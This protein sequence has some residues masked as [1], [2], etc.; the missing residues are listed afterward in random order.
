MGPFVLGGLISQLWPLSDAGEEPET[1][2]LT[3][4]PFVNY[5]FGHGEN[6]LAHFRQAQVRYTRPL[7]HR[8]DIAMAVE[9]PSP[10][11]TDAEGVNLTPDFI[12]RLRWE[13]REGAKSLLTSPAHVQEPC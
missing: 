6:A 12:A 3:L 5:N 9:N 2:H 11:L 8:L 4:Q 13:P 7:R 10:D 1:N